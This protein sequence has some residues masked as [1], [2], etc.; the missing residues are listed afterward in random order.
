MRCEECVNWPPS[1]MGN[2]PCCF[3]YPDTPMNYF[4]RKEEQKDMGNTEFTEKAKKLVREYTTDHLDKADKTPVFEV[5]VVW[6][7]YILGNAKA[8]LSTTLPDGMYYEVTYNK[9]KKE[10]YLDAYKKFENICF[11]V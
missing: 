11:A 6:N 1:A 10:I 2:K 8:L 9:A 4:Q 7:A 5:F 3:C